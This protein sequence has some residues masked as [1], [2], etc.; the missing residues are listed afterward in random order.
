MSRTSRYSTSSMGQ[1]DKEMKNGHSGD[2]DTENKI[3]Y[4]TRKQK[5]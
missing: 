5:Q 3:L 1:Y 2:R 4:V